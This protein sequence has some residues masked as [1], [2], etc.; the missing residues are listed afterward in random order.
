MIALVVRDY[1]SLVVVDVF[2]KFGRLVLLEAGTDA[3]VVVMMV[4]KVDRAT[5][6]LGV[7][8]D[9][10]VIVVMD[11]FEFAGGPSV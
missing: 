11:V 10:V 4:A 7:V 8:I 3:L 2:V 1:L 5:D 9:A 6:G